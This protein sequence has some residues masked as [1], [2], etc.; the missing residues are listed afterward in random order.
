MTVADEE[1][2]LVRKRL[3]CNDFALAKN[4]HLSLG[5]IIIFRGCFLLASYQK[6][7]R[8]ATLVPS[9]FAEISA[10]SK[11]NDVKSRDT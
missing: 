9:M 7:N 1:T 5:G 4:Q 2:C 6:L 11:K 8:T 10:K 3:P